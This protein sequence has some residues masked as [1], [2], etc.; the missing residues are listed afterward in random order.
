MKTAIIS[1]IHVDVNKNYDVTGEIISYLKKN[2]IEL[3]IIAGDISS[4]PEKTIATIDNLEKQSGVKVLYVPG[5][6]DLWNKDG[7]YESNDAIYE[8][9]CKDEHCLSGKCFETDEHIIIGD[10]AWFDYSFGNTMYSKEEFDK[11][12]MDGRTW[13]DYLFNTWS[14]DNVEKSD[15]FIKKFEEAIL[16][17]RVDIE[18]IKLKTEFGAELKTECKYELKSEIDKAKS[19]ISGG[20]L[21]LV[22]DVGDMAENQVKYKPVT[23]HKKIVLVTH[24]LSNKAFT[25][26]EDVTGVNWKYF[27]AFLGSKALQE[28]C[29]KY[30]DDI[31]YAICGHV[32]YRKTVVENRVT[33]MC[34]CLN[35]HKEWLND[36]LRE[37]VEGAIE[38]VDL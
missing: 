11:M 13:Q 35:Y 18:Q 19:H 12:S 16:K 3:L 36:N 20:V 14:K 6:H 10:V 34:R 25:V 8:M 9:Y 37:Q 28:L 7:K 26:P 5:N 29:E 33:Y 23:A 15:W 38:V 21:N 24:M 17:N 22:K 2:N 1:D 4:D 27:N 31:D 32:H 30:S